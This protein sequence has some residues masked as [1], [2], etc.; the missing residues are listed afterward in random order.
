[1][2]SLKDIDKSY[3]KGTAKIDILKSLNLEVKE[4]DFLCLYGKSGCGKS[5]LLNILGLI[6]A[7]SK[8][9]YF[10]GQT[11]VG[12]LSAT[13]RAEYR[14]MYMGYVF[15][16]FYLIPEL[17]VAQNIELSM[18]YAGVGRKDRRRRSE[19]LMNQFSLE[20]RSKYY[21]SQLSGGEK[22]R[23]AIARAL[24]NRPRII[25]ADEPTGS[26]DSYNSDV[27]MEELQK[28]NKGGITIIMVT[29]NRSLGHYASKN[30]EMKDGCITKIDDL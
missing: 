8:G 26:L 11:E 2:I 21:P 16:S 30:I 10:L 3:G 18:G 25:L 1:M 4:G 13:K 6:D 19:E 14:N 23:V 22:Q 17:N 24:A 29:H 27:I 5:T 28:L 9:E 12:K 15:Q 20:T 7:P